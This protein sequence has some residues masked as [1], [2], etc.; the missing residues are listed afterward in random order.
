MLKRFLYLALATV[1]LACPCLAADPA[2]A[3]EESPESAVSSPPMEMDDPGTPGKNGLEV[4]FV[5][6]LFHVGPG[7]ASEGLLDAN[8]GIGDRIQLK[9]ERPYI[10]E[11]EAGLGLQS[12]MGATELGIKWRFIDSHGLQVAFYPNYSFDDAFVLKDE[13]GDPEESEGRN[14]YFPLLVSENIGEHYTLAFNY[15]YRHNYEHHGDDNAVAL[16]V[17]R[18]I[19]HDARLLGEIFSERDTHFHNRQTD[20]RIGYCFLPFAQAFEAS[21]FE[22]PIYASLGH[23]IGATESTEP[24]TSFVFGVSFIV[25]P[26]N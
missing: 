24:A 9:Y 21:R 17:G 10:R 13:N 7:R 4:N 22:T 1:S 5:E 11:H 2:P 8:F 18:A 26:S 3:E 25:K 20:V 14:A 23:S 12:G 16:G 15:G 6:S 19:G